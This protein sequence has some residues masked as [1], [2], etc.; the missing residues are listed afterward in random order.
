MRKS[1][2]L[3]A[4][5]LLAGIFLSSCKDDTPPAKSD[6]EQRI[7]DLA[8]SWVLDA[9]SDVVT[10]AGRDVSTDW[11]AFTLNLDQKN[12]TTSG[13]DSPE[14]WPASGSWDFGTDINKLVRNDGIELSISVTETS[15]SIQF[16]YAAAG[17]RLS[18]IEGTWVFKLVPQ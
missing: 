12:Y 11:S 18:G 5:T 14:V 16:D 7:E 2:T 15:L 13:S 6:E 4:L 17:G 10:V 3:I 1:L 8:G 9:G